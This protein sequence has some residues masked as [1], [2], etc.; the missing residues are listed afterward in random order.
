MTR[1]RLTGRL[2]VALPPDQAFVLFTARGEERWAAGWAP[3][4]PVP[5]PDDAAPGTVFE[6]GGHHATTTTWLVVDSEPGRH[7]RYARVTPQVSAGTVD[8]RLDRTAA[9]TT[10]TVTY[11]LTPL[12][13]EAT[14]HL[15]AFAAGYQD[16]LASWQTS[17]EAALAKPATR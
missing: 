15:D 8:V 14:A 11:H 10:V 4:F 3:S 2:T 16:F 13:E 7:I 1:H 9:G 12:G 17:I 6:T 5:T